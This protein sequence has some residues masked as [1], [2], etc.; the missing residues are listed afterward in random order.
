MAGAESDTIERALDG[1]ADAARA[2]FE[3]ERRVAADVLALRSA[4]DVPSLVLSA[5]E[6]LEPVA[7]RL[8]QSAPPVCARGCSWCCRGVKVEATVA[9]AFAVAAFLRDG[10]SEDEQARI[11]RDARD[12]AEATRHLDAA[13]RWA[14]KTPCVFLDTASGACTIYA[15][16]PFVC[17][18]HASFDANACESAADDPSAEATVPRHVVPA[19]VFGT[20]KTAVIAACE[21]AGLDARH[22]ELASAVAVALGEPRTAE[23]WLD[24]ERLFDAAVLPS[25]ER[26]RVRSLRLLQKSGLLPPERLIAHVKSRPERNAAK[27]ARRERRTKR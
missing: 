22:F 18:S 6:R 4:A 16:R 15:A 11:A 27:R 17:R 19:H 3:A 12:R 5:C 23:R 7:E 14:Q 9:E 10:R 24:G 8:A 25:D 2:F 20:A 1:D 21:E 26:D 13:A